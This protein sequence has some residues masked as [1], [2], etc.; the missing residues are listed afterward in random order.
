MTRKASSAATAAP[1][2]N[3]S[4]T[5]AAWLAD[6]NRQQFAVAAAGTDIMLRGLAAM[7]KI[8]EDSTR[9]I[10]SRRLAATQKMRGP[11]QPADLLAAQAELLRSDMELARRER[12]HLLVMPRNAAHAGGGLSP[13]LLRQQEGLRQCAERRGLPF[14]P[15]KA[16][17]FRHRFDAVGAVG[18]PGLAGVLQPRQP[19]AHRAGCQFRLFGGR[20]GQV[21][22]PFGVRH[23]QRSRRDA[24]GQPRQCRLQGQVGRFSV[25]VRQG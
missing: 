19:L 25:G 4:T 8:H 24:V 7:R 18:A 13:P 23:R 9:Q 1:A 2:A 15:A 10:T 12:H 6:W 3:G 20:H 5:P 17:V 16:L 21:R 11:A 22:E 14:G